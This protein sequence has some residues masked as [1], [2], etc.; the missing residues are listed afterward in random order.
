MCDDGISRLDA[1]G[2]VFE[3]LFELLKHPIKGRASAVNLDVC[4]PS[5]NFDKNSVMFFHDLIYFTG[6]ISRK[7]LV[8]VL[9]IIFGDASFKMNDHLAILTAFK[10]ISR[11]DN[12]I[13]K[14]NIGETYYEYRFD[15][16]KLISTFRNYMLKSY[17]ERIYGN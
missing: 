3:P 1:I 2:D 11:H 4:D 5:K 10:S 7:E 14:S 13:Y 15:T 12:G 6:P 16:N 9:I 17:P 8:E